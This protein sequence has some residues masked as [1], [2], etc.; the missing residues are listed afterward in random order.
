MNSEKKR[1]RIRGKEIW[2]YLFCLPFLICFLAF[3]VYP[4]LYSLNVSLNQW[5][6]FTNMEFVGVKNYVQ[7]LTKDPLFWKSV[8][9]TF[10]LMAL[11]TPTTVFFGLL[12]A[13]V[14][15]NLTRGKRF[16]QTTTFYPYVITPVAIGFIFSYMFDWQ[17]GLINKLLTAAKILDSPFYWLQNPIAIKLIISIMIIWRYLGYY[18]MMFLASMTSISPEIYEAARVDGATSSQTFWKITVPVLRNSIFFLAITS[19]I[20]GLKMFEEP[21]LIFS[22]W[23]SAFAGAAG[24]PNNAALTVMWK[25]YNDA[26]RLDTRVGYAA[27]ESYVLFAII[28][29]ITVIMFRVTREKD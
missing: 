26:Y 8:V 15:Y 12:L 9:N 4:T 10:I 19:V 24:G 22:G 18:I 6:G 20:G 7:I 23:G 2:Q 5:N 11:S 13:Y 29:I 17:T 16:F 14:L 21:M 27:A 1:H 25:F 3:T 28:M